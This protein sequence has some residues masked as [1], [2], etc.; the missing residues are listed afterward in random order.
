MVLRLPDTLAFPPSEPAPQRRA[1]LYLQPAEPV[2]FPA[3]EEVP[4]TNRHLELRTALYQLLKLEIAATAT[5]GSDQFVYWNP[6]TARERLAPDVFVRLD[7]PHRPIRVW[8]TWEGG[9]P[10]LGVEIVSDSDASE[11]DW[12]DKLERYAAAAFREVVRFD[13]DDRESPSP[14][15][16]WDLIGGDLVER[17]PEDPDLR[18]CETLGLWWV[19]VP[20]D[21]LG[22]MLRLARDAAGASLLP[23]PDEVATQAQAASAEALRK[24][25]RAQK[26]SARFRGENARLQAE[27]TALKAQ[28]GVKARKPRKRR[29][30]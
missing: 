25:A 16:V 27:L 19:V 30:S 4:E 9:A 10:E 13:P 2:Y 1:H 12:D 23:T 28:L 7:R 26:E 21:A 6:R 29:S 11:S 24:A 18:F 20:H 3:S 8:K 15:R 14:L 5:I 17:S 22:P